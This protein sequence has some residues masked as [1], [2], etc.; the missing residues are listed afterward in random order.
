MKLNS[1]PPSNHRIFKIFI[2]T[3][4]FI[5]T[6]SLYSQNRVICQNKETQKYGLCHADTVTVAQTYDFALIITSKEFIVMKD[7]KWGTIGQYGDQMIPMMYDQIWQFADEKNSLLVK[8]GDKYGI[9]DFHGKEIVPLYNL[10][11]G[12][13]NTF[14]IDAHLAF[15][16]KGATFQAINNGKM[17]IFN[18]EGKIQFDFLYPFVQ[19]ISVH[20]VDSTKPAYSIFLVGEKE[21]FSFVDKKN[22]PLFNGVVVEDM[23]YLHHEWGLRT[24]AVKINKKIEFINLVTGA[25]IHPNEVSDQLE[26][27]NIVQNLEDKMGII[28]N[29]GL[30]K[31]PCI[32]HNIVPISETNFAT[33]DVH[34]KFG[35]IDYN[36]NIILEPIYD[37]VTEVCFDA[38]DPDKY[39]YEVFDGKYYAIFLYDPGTKKMKQVTEFIYEDITCYDVSDDGKIEAHLIDSKGKKGTMGNDGKVK[40]E[41]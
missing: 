9:V 7:G 28:G 30:I 4:L 14:Q 24:A 10:Q 35:I 22:K 2:S 25:I 33:V 27:Y 16:K 38:I 1:P 17:A 31:V 34:D 41:K 12:E 11:E 19:N 37:D 3:I 36:G 23:F 32:Y 39:P 6:F 21:K 26:T 13:I 8:K 15:L 5:T 29:D 20:P 40:M 18:I